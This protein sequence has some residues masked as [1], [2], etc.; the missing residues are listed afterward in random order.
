MP[1][2]LKY[3]YL[4]VFKI[5]IGIWIFVFGFLSACE[6]ATDHAIPDQ[7]YNTIV[8]DA[9][10]TNELKQQEI[11]L[12]RPF[13]D[14]NGRPEPV[15]G[16]TVN[17]TVN[18]FDVSFPESA[19]T[20]G[21]YQTENDV[22]ATIGQSYYLAVS[23]EGKT[24]NAVTTMVPVSQPVLPSFQFVPDTGLY[25]IAW[26]NPQYSPF[27]QAMFEAD[28]RWGHLPGYDPEDT[29]TK[30]RLLYYTLNTIDVSY[31][32]FPQDKEEVYFPYGSI[33]VLKKFSLTDDFTNY[34]RALLAET[35]WQGSLFED[36]R[37][38]L[39]TNISN[40]GLGYFGACSVIADT[41]VVQ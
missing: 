29:L 30:A 31:I 15:S 10:L 17:V 9:I 13:S 20:P 32:I 34:L 1:G 8:V 14:P 24:Y 4:K 12:S 37:G 36:A 40:G 7:V 18:G 26:N 25:K 16:A 41:V 19:L 11:R 2:I 27:E 33:A 5:K 35:E 39:P 3:I 21:L 23:F 22:A 38:N 28:I 6:E